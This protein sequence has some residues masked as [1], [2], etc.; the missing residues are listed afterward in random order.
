MTDRGISC[1]VAM[2][3]LGEL[4]IVF[5]TFWEFVVE[6]VVDEEGIFQGYKVSQF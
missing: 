1:I 2:H 5:K 4:E 6:V 3:V